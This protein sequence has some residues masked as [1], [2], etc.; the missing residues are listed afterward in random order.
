MIQLIVGFSSTVLPLFVR[1]AEMTLVALP[2]EE[3]LDLLHLIF[4]CI[5]AYKHHQLFNP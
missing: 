2:F 4:T 1:G 3:N 5:V